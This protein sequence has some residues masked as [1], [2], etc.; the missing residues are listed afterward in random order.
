MIEVLVRRAPDG[1]IAQLEVTGHAGFAEE[2]ADIVCA[3]VSALVVTALIGLKRVAR[4]PYEGKATSGLMYCKVAPGGDPETAARA[5]V[6]LE[7]TVL[8]LRDLA[9]DY[10][11]YVKVTEGG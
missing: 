1:S 7:T 2:G 4:H 6:I 8:G 3:G 10:H 9:K 5:Q 11:E